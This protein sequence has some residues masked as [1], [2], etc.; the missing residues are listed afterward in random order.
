MLRER[1]CMLESAKKK[2]AALSVLGKRKKKKVV[3]MVAAWACCHQALR[4]RLDRFLCRKNKMFHWSCTPLPAFQSCTRCFNIRTRQKLWESQKKLKKS[5]SSC[6]VRERQETQRHLKPL[7]LRKGM[8]SPI[9]PG[10]NDSA[11]VKCI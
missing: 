5:V 4:N 11:G 3:L 9:I 10:S 1:Q 7:F 6:S 2:R 8:I